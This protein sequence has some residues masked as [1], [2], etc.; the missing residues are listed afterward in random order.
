M[1]K[2]TQHQSSEN[3]A[4]G[5]PRE[6]DI[7][8]VLDRAIDVFRQRGYHATSINDLVEG[9]GLTR[10]SVYKA[11]TDKRSIFFAAYERY[12]ATRALATQQALGRAD[13]GRAKI[14]ALFESYVLLSSDENGI[15]GC[16]VVAAATELSVV[17]SEMAERI[18]GA[19]DR[20]RQLLKSLIRD[21]KRD[22]SLSEQIDEPTTIEALLCLL[23]GMRIVGK[24][25]PDT[26]VMSGVVNVAM[27]MLD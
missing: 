3:R 27:K 17:D 14:R 6:F 24:T 22:G 8:T 26:D 16:L 2:L 5:R 23:Q 13:S 9:M 18:T 25:A 10:G 11:F 21:G 1:K 15:K 19:F 7:D 20:N 4:P 12:A